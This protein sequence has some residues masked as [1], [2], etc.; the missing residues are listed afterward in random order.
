[1]FVGHFA[2]GLVTKRVEPSISLGTLVLA[3]MLA[4][5]LWPVFMMAGIERVR[6]KAGIGAANYVDVVNIAMSHSLVMDAIWGALF[7]AA[8]VA[9]RGRLRAAAILFLAVLSHWVLDVVS[10]RAD[11]PLL[12]GGHQ[13]FG[14]G[15]WTSIPATLVIE[16]GFWLAAIV[17]YTR[18][19]HP[20]NRTGVYAFWGGVSVLT[21]LWHNNIAGTPPPPHMASIGSLITFSIAV[22][23]AYWIDR[24]RPFRRA[25]APP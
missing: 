13:Y 4:D 22:A 18:V 10:H 8:Y 1:M 11:M 5:L 14:L 19:T 15:L 2:V 25:P 7:G 20:R 9:R 6:F 12:P 21:L 3:A 17:V 23:W 24:L 16:G